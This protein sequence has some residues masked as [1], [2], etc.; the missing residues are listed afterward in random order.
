MGD[1]QDSDPKIVIRKRY[2]R[3]LGWVMTLAAPSL[4]SVLVFRV[5]SGEGGIGAT[6]LILIVPILAAAGIWLAG[7]T[8]TVTFSS[9][10]DSMTV[11]RGYVPL[12][13]WWQR[14]KNISRE[15]ARTV[16]ITTREYS[17][18]TEYRVEVVT[19]PGKTLFLFRDAGPTD[20]NE[21]K[22]GI[23]RWA[24]LH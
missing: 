20:A 15:T 17:E 19:G 9:Y 1:S 16:R 7:L 2:A 14:T 18:S 12:F 24:G 4:L 22:N 3:L 5:V 11:T 8:T 21:I 13:V 6:V 23:R 10:S